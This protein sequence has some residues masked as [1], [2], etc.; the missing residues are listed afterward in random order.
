MAHR[1]IGN[2]SISCKC[3][4]GCLKT[5]LETACLYY[6]KGSFV[7][8][9]N[10][11]GI[12]SAGKIAVI[13]GKK[14]GDLILNVLAALGAEGILLTCSAYACLDGNDPL[15]VGVS[16]LNN[17]GEYLVITAIVAESAD[18]VSGATVGLSGAVGSDSIS[19]ENKLMLGTLGN[20]LLRK[21][22]D[23]AKLAVLT[24]GKTVSI[25]GS[26][27][28]VNGFYNLS[29]VR[30]SV[31]GNLNLLYGS[32][33]TVFT[34][35]SVGKTGSNAGLSVA[36]HYLKILSKVRSGGD[37]LSN[38]Y[39]GLADIA[40]NVIAKA[41]I[42]TGGSV[43]GSY[44][45]VIKSSV[46]T[47]GENDL[48]SLNSGKAD[49]A[50]STAF[51]ACNGTGRLNVGSSNRLVVLLRNN[52]GL[53]KSLVA[54]G[55][56]RAG[57]SAGSRAGRLNS[58]DCNDVVTGCGNNCCGSLNVTALHAVLLGGKAVLGTGS[59]NSSLGDYKLG[60]S[61][62]LAVRVTVDLTFATGRR[63][64]GAAARTGC[65]KKYYH[66]K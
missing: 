59:L 34:K 39:V 60:V 62:M 8:S 50:V 17:L 49:S 53:H 30:I 26:C 56:L 15:A 11:V 4:A 46:V 52:S 45:N 58:C 21:V 48:G 33:A 55:A 9:D 41:L 32:N 3:K 31:N 1:L 16:I 35:L 42:L 65:E 10:S 20:S 14:S 63:S 18:V 37:G 43:T 12:N 61:I 54:R 19:N 13:L 2:N 22:G 23:L 44:L 38:D 57:S 40:I 5:L 66:K 47:V 29:G 24:V 25:T 28:A 51:G 6:I 64:L 36:G 7:L 27:I